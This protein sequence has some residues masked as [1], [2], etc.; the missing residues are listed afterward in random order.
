MNVPMTEEMKKFPSNKGKESFM[1]TDIVNFHHERLSRASTPI[2]EIL[3]QH[4][5][6]TANLKKQLKAIMK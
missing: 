5:F 2:D 4:V 1:R 6:D 3:F